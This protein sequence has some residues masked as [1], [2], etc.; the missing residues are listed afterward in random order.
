MDGVDSS[1]IPQLA[2]VLH[3]QPASAA[4]TLGGSDDRDGLG[5]EQRG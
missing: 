4:G 3:D 5:V 1:P 2:Q